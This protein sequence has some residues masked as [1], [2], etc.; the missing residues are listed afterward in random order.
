VEAVALE[1]HCRWE[2]D[3]AHRLA[4]LRILRQGL[5]GDALL[6]LEGRAVRAPVHIG[7]HDEEMIALSPAATGAF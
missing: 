4:G 7:R 6:A 5:V 3:A 2:E 1:D